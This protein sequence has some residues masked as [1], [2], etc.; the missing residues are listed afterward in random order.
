MSDTLAE[1]AAIIAHYDIGELTACERDRRGYVNT[2]Y[3][4]QTTAE[5]QSKRYFLRQYKQ[6][7]TEAE[8]VFEHS[9]IN[10]LLEKNF[11]LA[12]RVLRTR[13]GQ[14]YVWQDAFYAVF[15]FLP[16][17]D[18]YT[19]VNPLCSDQELQNAAVILARFHHAV[20]D[21]QPQGRR[22]QPPIVDLL[23]SIAQ[24]AAQRIQQAVRQGSRQAGSTVF[25]VYLKTLNDIPGSIQNT[26]RALEQRDCPEMIR[27]VIHGD[28][29]PGNL[30][31]QGDRVTGVFDFDW[32]KID[33][34]CFDVALAVMYFCAVWHRDG[35]LDLERA[36]T[37]LNAY[38]A[39]LYP[40]NDAELQCLPHMI[41]AGN[42]YV[43]HWTIGD[44]YSNL[45]GIEDPHEY[46]R[47][48]QHNAR[49]ARWLRAN[50]N[51]LEEMTHEIKNP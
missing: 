35:R 37:F 30:K 2:S 9:I 33:V 42:F 43:L 27:Q 12:A 51:A 24:N 4:I 5:G 46:L 34:R 1:L 32:S 41:C 18:K 22:R 17:D 36:A 8:I 19:W 48:L 21:L 25:D 14:T 13:A 49:L 16:G 40:L 47:Y 39:A 44:F 3:A 45:A 31:F 20:A 28:Y 29:H 50:W 11:G 38:Q 26:L 10:H 6:E 15:D 23:P 7:I